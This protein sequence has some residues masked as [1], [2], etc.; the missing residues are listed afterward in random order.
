MIF[1]E[2]L[3]ATLAAPKKLFPRLLTNA[4]ERMKLSRDL[5]R[6]PGARTAAMRSSASAWSSECRF[7]RPKAGLVSLLPN[8]F[9]KMTQKRFFRTLQLEVEIQKFPCRFDRNTKFIVQCSILCS[10]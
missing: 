10:A 3:T 4:R 8:R 9:E 7:V 5:N 2:S 6:R 1:Q